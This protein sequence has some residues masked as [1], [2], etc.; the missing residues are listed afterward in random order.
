MNSDEQALAF[1]KEMDP[2]LEKFGKEALEVH[3]RVG[4]ICGCGTCFCCEAAL[5]LAE[6]RREERRKGR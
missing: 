5:Y 4:R 1:R 6:L 3:A 2:I